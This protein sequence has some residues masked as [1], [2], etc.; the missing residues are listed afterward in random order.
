MTIQKAVPQDVPAIYACCVNAFRDYILLIGRTPGPML[1]DYWEAVR[2]HP[3]F[4]AEEDGEMM[5]FLL[6]KDG[7]GDYMW[8]DVLAAWPQGRGAGSALMRQCETYIRSQGKSE[9]RL[10]T[11]VKYERTISLY[12]RNGYEIYDRVQEFGF[13]RYYK[14][15]CLRQ[16]AYC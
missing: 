9:C 8:M 5:G 2:D 16:G 10:Y 7:D 14:K 12:L 13:D 15:K 6:I 11:H 4:V 1:E 3:V